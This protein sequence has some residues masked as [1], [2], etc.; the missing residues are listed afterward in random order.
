MEMITSR[1]G[2]R[3]KMVVCGDSQQV[4]LKYKG[5]SGFKFLVTA[6]KKIKDMDSQTLFNES[7]TPSGRC[8]FRCIFRI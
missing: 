3:S 7:Q 2:L 8:T 6:A 4:D 1:L 5:D